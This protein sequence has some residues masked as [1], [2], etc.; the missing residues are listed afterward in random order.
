[1]SRCATG[2]SSAATCCCWKPSAAALPGV[3]RSCATDSA[4]AKK[5]AAQ[6]RGV[7]IVWARRLLGNRPLEHP[8]DLLIGRVAAR[9]AGMGRCHRLVGRAL[10]A[11]GGLVGRLGRAVRLISGALGPRYVTLH[12]GQL[13]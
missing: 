5:N 7:L 2:A 4:A 10:R 13:R 9:L 8:V 1:M 3:R 6:V 12:L 11:T